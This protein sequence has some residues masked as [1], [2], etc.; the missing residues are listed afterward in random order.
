MTEP[1]FAASLPQPPDTLSG[2]ATFL[3]SCLGRR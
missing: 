1:A 2:M 3:T